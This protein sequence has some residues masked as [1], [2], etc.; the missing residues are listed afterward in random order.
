MVDL[1]WHLPTG[2]VDR[3]FNPKVADAPVRQVATLVVRVD[4]HL[5]PDSPRRP[6][7]VRCADETGF[8]HLV[9]FHA[10]EDWLSG[11]CRW[12]NGGWSAARSSR[13]DDEIQITHPDHVAPLAEQ[14]QA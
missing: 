7:R 4:A 1:L 6:Y 13:F 5:P 14:G 10:R 11:P 2:I 9:Y 3:R 8:L 12:A